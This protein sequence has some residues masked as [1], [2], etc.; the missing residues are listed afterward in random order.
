MVVELATLP[1]EGP[2]WV[3]RLGRE[4]ASRELKIILHSQKLLS[5]P[6]NFNWGLFELDENEGVQDQ[7]TDVGEDIA[8]EYNQVTDATEDVP[9]DPFSGE[10]VD[11]DVSENNPNNE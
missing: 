6:G 7:A 3:P 11:Y 2:S 1:S 5:K 10:D 9:D 4:F 8:E